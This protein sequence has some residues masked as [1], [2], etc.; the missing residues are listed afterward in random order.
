MDHTI[1]MKRI[2][3]LLSAGDL[4]GFSQHVADDFIEHD[5]IPGVPPTKDGLMLYFE[6]MLTAFP[7][8]R[9]D[10]KDVIVSGDKAV[11]RVQVS[12]THSDEFMGIPATDKSF[13]VNLI[14]IMRFGEDGLAHEH[15]GV[16]DQLLMMQQLGIIPAMG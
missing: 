1:S 5:E 13:E 6:M 9:M 15:W 14:D 3:E 2:Y 4:E 12:G 10:V 11:A 7:D 8:M 16:V